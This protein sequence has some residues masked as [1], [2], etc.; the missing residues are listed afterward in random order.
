MLGG[1]IMILDLNC[2]SDL[3]ALIEK[4]REEIQILAKQG[5]DETK[6]VSIT[7]N[8][9]GLEEQLLRMKS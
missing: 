8:L 5:S 7:R 4:R 2:K 9:E 6:L 1:S 3:E